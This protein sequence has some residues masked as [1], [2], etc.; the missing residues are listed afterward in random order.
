MDSPKG[1]SRQQAV[2]Q[3]NR[4]SKHRLA[5]HLQSVFKVNYP[6]ALAMVQALI[7][8]QDPPPPPPSDP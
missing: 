1:S 7:D 2:N 3:L 5:K 4:G 6:K 8:I